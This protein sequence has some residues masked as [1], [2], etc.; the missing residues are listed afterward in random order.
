MR[1]LNRRQIRNMLLQE[2]KRA[3][4]L[5]ESAL[6]EVLPEDILKQISEKL[7]NPM[8]AMA[9]AMKLTLEIQ[10]AG[11]PIPPE[12]PEQTAEAMTI[13]IKVA[14]DMGLKEVLDILKSSK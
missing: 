3:R 4:L 10:A 8:T 7:T 11:I 6:P 2:V 9:F 1:K 5:K 13:A 12:T 14:A